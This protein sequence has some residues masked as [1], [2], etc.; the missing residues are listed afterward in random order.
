MVEALFSPPLLTPPSLSAAST[1]TPSPSQATL[2][3]GRDECLA[4]SSNSSSACSSWLYDESQF[5]GSIVERW[6]ACLCS[7]AVCSGMLDYSYVLLV[8]VPRRVR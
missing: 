8:Y 7:L 5:G 1:P 3:G 4:Y 2:E 6:V